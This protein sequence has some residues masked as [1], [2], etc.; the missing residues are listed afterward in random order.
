LG[1]QNASHF[2]ASPGNGARPRQKVTWTDDATPCFTGVLQCL[3]PASGEKARP[4][5]S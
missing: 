4:C 3:R 1:G 2:S 5:F